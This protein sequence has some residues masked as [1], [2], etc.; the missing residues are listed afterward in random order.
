MP[1]YATL[2][3]AP[4]TGYDP[5]YGGIPG[6]PNPAATGGAAIA[7]N[8]SNLASLYGMTG[9]LNRFSAGQ[10]ALPFDINLPGYRQMTAASSR[11]IQSMLSG[12][13]PSDVLRQIEQTA[14][15]RGISRGIPGGPNANAAMLRLLG[16]TSVGQQQA[17]EA[18][19]TG[20]MARTPQG[21]QFNAASFLTTPEQQQAAQMAANIYGA[22]PVPRAASQAAMVPPPRLGPTTTY[23]PSAGNLLP[24][25]GT[26]MGGGPADDVAYPSM[27]TGTTIGGE[28]YQPGQTPGSEYSDWQAWNARM[29]WSQTATASTGAPM[30]YSADEAMSSFPGDLPDY[31]GY[32]SQDDYYS[33]T[34]E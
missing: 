17:G 12:Q 32:T 26:V 4:A 1:P 7:G 28:V 10:A 13:V 14:A 11:N 9:S 23:G 8:L 20:A 19:F 6:V 25:G 34:G 31:S 5:A 15:E 27:G 22:A 33:D 30:D 3:P 24:R 21:P 2:P 18:A 29:P 16:L